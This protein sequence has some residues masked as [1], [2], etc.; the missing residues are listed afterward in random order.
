MFRFDSSVFRDSSPSNSTSIPTFNI[1]IL[2]YILNTKGQFKPE[3]TASV[4]IIETICIP[5]LSCNF[6]LQKCSHIW[7]KTTLQEGKRGRESPKYEYF[8]ILNKGFIS[9]L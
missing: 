6:A 4:T 9:R 1:E 2:Y 8:F 3:K 7:E 5:F